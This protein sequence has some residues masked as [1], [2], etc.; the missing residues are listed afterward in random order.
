M[1]E[2]ADYSRLPP[3]A[4]DLERAVLG[5]LLMSSD[6][7][8]V[9]SQFLK[10]EMFYTEAHQIIYETVLELFR[11][12][13]PIDLLTVA[14]A[15]R[16]GEHLE[17]IGGASYVAGLTSN[18]GVGSHAS[19]HARIIQEKYIK[20]EIIRVSNEVTNMAYD[21]TK[22]IDDILATMNLTLEGIHASI[23]SGLESK[24]FPELIEQS[25]EEYVDREAMFKDNK[26]PGIP[27]GVVDLDKMTGG[28]KD[29]EL[30]IVAGR[31]GMGKTAFALGCVKQASVEGKWSNVYSL[32]MSAVLLV[33]RLLTGSANVNSEKYRDGALS[34]EEYDRMRSTANEHVNDKIIIDPR[35]VVTMEYVLSNSRINMKKGKCDMIVIDYLQLVEES[36][37]GGRNREQAVSDISRKSKLIAKELNVPVL[38]LAQLNRSCELRG[39][40]KRPW[41][42]DL[43]E[44]GSIEQ[45]ADVVAF[46]FREERYDKEA[47]KGKGELIISKQRNG[48]VGTVFFGYNQ[49]MT[50]I[51]D[52]VEK[53]HEI[54]DGNPDG[55]IEPWNEFPNDEESKD[56]PF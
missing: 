21:E 49:E 44:S 15:L 2:I 27:T 6:V 19:F 56:K 43:R 48:R 52:Y 35:P 28:W 53:G 12:H 13:S 11:K 10:P 46:L 31:P 17:M 39:S 40:D 30:I 38:M 41:L 50:K 47:T 16:K 37:K 29:S 8:D 51:F 7:I 1:N 55:F 23:F 14:E 36:V 26:V 4:T 32:E 54:A 34:N 3:Q 5:G 20:R 45:D 24:S 33:D 22:D 25:I 9:V 42:A 18:I